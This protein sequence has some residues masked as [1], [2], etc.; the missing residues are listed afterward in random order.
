MSSSQIIQ[1]LSDF[2][3]KFILGKLSF[4]SYGLIAGH[5]LQLAPSIIF[6]VF[7]IRKI[8]FLKTKVVKIKTILLIIFKFRD[9]LFYRLPSQFFLSYSMQVPL[10]FFGAFYTKEDTG[11]LSLALMTLSVP[12]TLIANNIG[13]V[14]YSEISQI[15][16]NSFLKKVTYNTIKKSMLL[17]I[18]PTGILFFGGNILYR[19]VFG[20]E[21][22]LAGDFAEI[23]SINLFFQFITLPLINIF[24]VMRENKFFLYINIIRSFV[25]TT[26]FFIAYIYG[27]NSKT[28][29]Y[30]Y[31]IFAIAYYIYFLYNVYRQ[32][33]KGIFND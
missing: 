17:A 12:V 10:V 21:W 18:I 23:L 1:A 25:T 28:V 16:S 27:L 20:D 22:A 8:S 2:S 7:H 3:L 29:I 9:F 33:N 32:I 19:F 11:Q 5:S 26:P 13:Y 30:I 31:V 6:C 24:T 4:S 14:F 15:R